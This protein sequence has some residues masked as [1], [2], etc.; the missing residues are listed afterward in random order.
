M[1][2]GFVYLLKMTNEHA[3]N[4]YKIGITKNDVNKRIKQLQTGNHNEIT[5]A[6]T[7]ETKHY[8]K[9][10]SMLHRKFASNHTRGE[11]FEIEEEKASQFI[12]E[13]EAFE[14]VVIALESNC[15]F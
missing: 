15:F 5:V 7:F 13:C 1:K 10:E 3:E 6:N 12:S 11:W 2:K 4:F 8:F 14:N 9:I